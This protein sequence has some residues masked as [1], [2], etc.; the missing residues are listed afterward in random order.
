MALAQ[1]PE[2]MQRFSQLPAQRRQ[3]LVAQARNA[4][5][6]EAMQAL[7]QSLF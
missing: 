5:T 1:R 2:A 6:R 7:V 3:Q 4:Q